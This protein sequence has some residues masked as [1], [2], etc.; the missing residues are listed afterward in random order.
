MTTKSPSESLDSTKSS[1][2]LENGKEEPKLFI[3][4]YDKVM[5]ILQFNQ[6]LQ[7]IINKDDKKSIHNLHLQIEDVK[8][9]LL[10][11]QTLKKLTDEHY[12]EERASDIPPYIY[13]RLP[14]QLEEL[15]SS[16]K[17]CSTPIIDI[18]NKVEKSSLLSEVKESRIIT[19]FFGSV[20]DEKLNLKR[21]IV[22]NTY[23]DTQI[24]T[25]ADL[26]DE[27]RLDMEKNSSAYEKRL[28]IHQSNSISK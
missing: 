23:G 2:T 6:V 25:V 27:L 12:P 3:D 13:R 26:V 19:D 24:S 1:T 16:I 10:N 9:L 28:G 8:P 21:K 7:F 4:D 17:A 18:A 20:A 14:N 5:K 15:Q 11:N 22:T